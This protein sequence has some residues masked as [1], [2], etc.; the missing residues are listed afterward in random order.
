MPLG[1]QYELVGTTRHLNIDASEEGLNV[2]RGMFEQ[3]TFKPKYH[4][5]AAYL[6]KHIQDGSW[7]IGALLPSEM[8]LVEQFSVSRN[9]VREA[10]K[11]LENSGYIFRVHGKGSYVSS[12]RLNQRFN[13]LT[14]FSEDISLAGM[15]PGHRNFEIRKVRSSGFIATKLQ[16]PAESECLFLH[17]LLLADGLAFIIVK[18][19]LPFHWLEMAG[20]DISEASLG[21]GSLYGFLKE[22]YGVVFA[23]TSTTAKAARATSEESRVLEIPRGSPVLATERLSF[24]ADDI[25]RE[26]TFGTGHPDRHQWTMMMYG[27]V[28]SAPRR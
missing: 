12:I 4:Q 17:R 18:T 2:Q 15:T 22:R 27:D 16:V 13:N 19:Y 10:M 14:S 26:L 6:R 1:I 7:P 28:D 9:T 8:Q 11:E 23:K 3:T 24:T 25:P 20:I 21:E 5:L